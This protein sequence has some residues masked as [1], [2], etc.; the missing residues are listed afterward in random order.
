MTGDLSAFEVYSANCANRS[1]EDAALHAY[2]HATTAQA[3][4]LIEGALERVAQ[5][6]GIAY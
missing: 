6:E 5:A 3:R 4:A 2:M 1:A